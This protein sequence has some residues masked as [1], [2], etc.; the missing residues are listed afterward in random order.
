MSVVQNFFETNPAI[1][2]LL[3][4][5]RLE[6]KEKMVTCLLLF[7]IGGVLLW[8]GFNTRAILIFPGLVLGA[9]ALRIFLILLQESDPHRHQ[10][11]HILKKNP[12]QIVWI[13]S[14]CEERMPFGIKIAESG[15]LLF[16]LANREEITLSLPVKQLSF[17][18]Q[19]LNNLLPHATFG[20]SDDRQQWYLADPY[21]LFVYPDELQ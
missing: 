17:I 20:Y 9:F 6:W 11:I 15:T 3:R 7:L 10:L 18:T 14:V 16:K 2:F 12:Q 1:P 19:S 8:Y 21:L 13:Y 4:A 5:I